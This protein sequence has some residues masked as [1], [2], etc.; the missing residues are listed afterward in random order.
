MPRE[1]SQEDRRKVVDI[2][3]R[4][5]FADEG[6]IADISIHNPISRNDN[7]QQPHAHILITERMFKDGDFVKKK[8]R[9]IQ[10]P[11]YLAAIRESWATELNKVLERSGVDKRVD[12]RSLVEQREDAFANGDYERA[13][14][15]T[16]EPVRNIKSKEYLK[17]VKAENDHNV[18][19]ILKRYQMAVKQDKGIQYLRKQ[20][21]MFDIK[22]INND[23]YE[24]PLT[25]SLNNNYMQS[26][27]PYDVK[28]YIE[29]AGQFYFG[30]NKNKRSIH[31]DFN[32]GSEVVQHSDWVVVKT[33][34][35]K[36]AEAWEGFKSVISS[37][38]FRNQTAKK[39]D[40]YVTNRIDKL[41][42]SHSKIPENL[43][44]GGR[45]STLEKNIDNKDSLRNRLSKK[46][47][48][49]LYRA[50]AKYDNTSK[51]LDYK[52]SSNAL[53]KSSDLIKGNQDI[54]TNHEYDLTMNVAKQNDVGRKDT[55]L[56]AL[57][58]V[59]FSSAYKK[60][61]EA[62]QRLNGYMSEYGTTKTMHMLNEKPEYFGK[63]QGGTLFG[64]E[65]RQEA[66]AALEKIEDSVAGKERLNAYRDSLKMEYSIIERGFVG[67][68]GNVE[69]FENKIADLKD[70]K[71]ALKTNQQEKF[72]GLNNTEKALLNEYRHKPEPKTNDEYKQSTSQK[73][74]QKDQFSREYNKKE[75]SQ[76]EKYKTSAKDRNQHLGDD[77]IKDR[78]EAQQMKEL[79]AYNEANK[80]KQNKDI[81]IEQS[82]EN[83]SASSSDDELNKSKDLGM[84]R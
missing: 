6:Y 13:I 2:F 11:E 9:L 72:D 32:G 81:K 58:R 22:S 78:R 43:V 48:S 42:E 31:S 17:E 25:H 69:K 7:L 68:N 60:G 29:D 30:K 34:A 44:S 82:K 27:S 83:E 8:D 65:K 33:G 15:L 76:N 16:R 80:S 73:Y 71:T 70:Q 20:I 19:E 55:D 10:K 59:G 62:E 61:D 50:G 56:S 67:R 37:Q 24:P 66:F 49:L 74:K 84:E 40:P 46:E 54:L 39:H 79:T 53:Q 18:G 47:V 38:E 5:N 4:K 64:R 77:G 26:N 41:F 12:A 63:L 35:E 21:D 14:E 45:S 51:I 23:Y 3:T 36:R 57:M 52:Q 1:L 28:N 75:Y